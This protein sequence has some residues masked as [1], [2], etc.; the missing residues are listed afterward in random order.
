[1]AVGHMT[2]RSAQQLGDRCVA[3]MKAR[4]LDA[5]LASIPVGSGRESLFAIIEGHLIQRCADVLD[6]GGAA[7]GAQ[8]AKDWLFA[9]LY[10]AKS[11]T[12]P[13]GARRFDVRPRE[14]CKR[15]LAMPHNAA[16]L[17]HAQSI[18]DSD[19]GLELHFVIRDPRDAV[20]S[21]SHCVVAR[22]Y[23]RP[24]VDELIRAHAEL[25]LARAVLRRPGLG[26]D[27]A[28]WSR[29]VGVVLREADLLLQPT[30][31]VARAMDRAI[32]ELGPQVILVG[33]PCT[34]DGV[35]TTMVAR[36]HRLPTVSLQHGD[37]RPENDEWARAQVDT[38]MVWGTYARDVLFEL[39][40][41]PGRVVVTGAPWTDRLVSRQRRVDRPRV[42]VALSGA[43]HSVGMNEHLAHV[44]RLIAASAELPH[45]DWR[46]RLHR[47]D[48]PEIYRRLMSEIPGSTGTIVETRGQVTTIYEDLEPARALIT[49]T[50][51]SAQDGMMVGVPV[52]TLGRPSGEPVPAYVEQRATVHVEPDEPLAAR[53]EDV[54][55]H[56]AGEEIRANAQRFVERYFGPVD[57]RSSVRVASILSAIAAGERR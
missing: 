33:N 6:Q 2:R 21:A 35:V 38:L 41:D 26:L 43:G 20:R 53:L 47:K 29:L 15:V 27:Q 8:R 7:P 45:Y 34:A 24:R 9:R 49:V 51:A 56:G 18:A 57:G 11:L 54:V 32:D 36:Q 12:L 10:R 46:F 50:S 30:M 16:Q 40:V 1:M 31:T 48:D 28:T 4:L 55:E 39:G 37:I 5:G 13:R 17:V 25:A 42:L 52:V 22:A 3:E 44:R 19:A 14:G 23:A